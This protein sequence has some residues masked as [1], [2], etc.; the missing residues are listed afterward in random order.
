MMKALASG[1]IKA[2]TI[3]D[4]LNLMNQGGIDKVLLCSWHGPKGPIIT[5]ETI[6]KFVKKYPDRFIG[7]ASVDL[8]N[9]IQALKT[10]DK[11]V[12]EYNFKALRI[13]QWVWGLPPNHKLYYPLYAKCIE[14]DIPV[15]LQVGHTG[16]LK[17]SETGRPIPY[18]DEIALTFP[19]LKIVCGHI[20][21]P[22]TEE[23]IA[24]SWKHKNVYIDTSAYLPKYYPKNLI[25]YMKT[26]GKHKVMFG[27]NFPQLMWK[28]CMKHISS[29]G[30]DSETE[31]LFIS[32]NARRVFKLAPLPSKVERKSK[33]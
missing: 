10:L 17:T 6:Y 27:T 11:C 22:W 18:I 33:L 12:K 2:P 32:G 19:E 3:E 24:V 31:E 28:R 25:H 4:H 9:P 14:L 23:M 29:L 30:L 8:E 7:V 13:V 21:Y 15:C 16:P 5:N 26:Y 20:G 1:E